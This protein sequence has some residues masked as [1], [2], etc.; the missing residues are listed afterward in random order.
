M[1]KEEKGR[2]KAKR[3]AL[4]KEKGEL[5]YVQERK[6]KKGEVMKKRRGKVRSKIKDKKTKEKIKRCNR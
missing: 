1:K 6:G 4:V 5:L 2:G 3:R